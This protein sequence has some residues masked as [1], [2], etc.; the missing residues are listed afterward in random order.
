[1]TYTQLPLFPA[2]EMEKC[3]KLP[4][5]REWEKFVKSTKGATWQADRPADTPQPGKKKR[6]KT[7]SNER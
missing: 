3:V 5:D 4:E 6:R 2:E 1:M 7:R